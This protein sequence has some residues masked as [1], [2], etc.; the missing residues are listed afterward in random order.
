MEI[1]L[2]DG[3]SPRCF[4][5]LQDNIPPLRFKKCLCGKTFPWVKKD[6][7][8]RTENKCEKCSKQYGSKKLSDDS[9]T[10]KRKRCL[11]CSNTTTSKLSKFCFNCDP[12][13]TSK[14]KE[15]IEKVQNDSKKSMSQI[16][17]LTI[18]SDK[19][20]AKIN[21]KSKLPT[22][23]NIKPFPIISQM[24][25][26]FNMTKYHEKLDNIKDINSSI[27]E[28]DYAR[29]QNPGLNICFLNSAVQFILS[30]KPLADLLCCQY[31]EKFCKS[32]TFLSEYER[33]EIFENPNQS[34]STV[35]L[36]KKNFLKE[37]ETLVRNMIRNTEL[38]F[39]AEK[40]AKIFEVLEP[41]YTYYNQWDCSSV[42][43]LFFT[44]YEEFLYHEDFE[45]KN[46]A[47]RILDSLKILTSVSIQCKMCN[48]LKVEQIY[49]NFLFVP[50]K[51][52]IDNIFIPFFND[53]NEYCCEICNDIAGNS[54]ARIVTGAI[55]KTEIVS[56][57]KYVLVK[58]GRVKLNFEKVKY[59]VTLNENNKVFGRHL[60]LEAWVE[61]A[62]ET[63][64]SGHYFLIRRVKEG[65][66]KIS[67]NYVSRYNKNYIK[68][69]NSCYVAMLK[70]T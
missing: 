50:L 49:N 34:I 3:K 47:Q 30:I 2:S 42:I 18:E 8:T 24:G 29:L 36:A 5:C 31:V 44:L 6:G 23:K 9:F 63:I 58:F 28:C 61:H 12:R 64:M 20:T 13:L 69:C 22:D 67:D 59:T 66:I 19:T 21:K 10:R 11:S 55:E 62:G 14:P 7:I 32:E 40:L 46:N 70:R 41:G 33:L 16:M 17:K 37:F 15:K 4:E 65:C 54:H 56:F 68:N 53:I 25:L 27:I 1:C 45:G 38:Y 26:K 35:T 48:N 39:S 43:D 57:S 51:G 52:N 60:R